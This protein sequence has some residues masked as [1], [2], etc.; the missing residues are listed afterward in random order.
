MKNFI[1]GKFGTVIILLFTVILAGVAIF[2]ALRLYQLRSQPVAP[3]VPSSIPRAQE[4][5][6]SP[7]T[8]GACSLSFTVHLVSPSP[9][10]T[11]TPTPTPI[12]QCND[13]CTTSANCPSS[14]TCFIGSGATSGHCRNT[15]C[16]SE[17]GCI[18]PTATPTPTPTAAPNLCGGTCGSDSN[19]GSGLSCYQGFCR[20][21]SCPS[22]SSCSCPGTTAPTPTPAAPALPVSGTDWPTIVGAGFGLFVIIGSLL[23][24]L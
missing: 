15:Q 20:N 9:T 14:L 7:T 8:S 13:T 18:C 10:P 1:K 22:Q 4:V 24:A 3:N 5:S 19:C 23:L 6:P 12:P 16:S 17:V 2:T 11:P 21:P